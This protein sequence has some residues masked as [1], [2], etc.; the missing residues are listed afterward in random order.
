MHQMF[1]NMLNSFYVED[2]HVNLLK[3]MLEEQT[4]NFFDQKLD[5]KKYLKIN[6]EEIKKKI[7]KVEERFAVGEIEKTF[8]EK[9]TKKFRKEQAQ[10]RKELSQITLES[11][12][13]KKVIEYKL[14]ISRK[15]GTLLNEYCKKWYILRR[16]LMIEEQTKFEPLE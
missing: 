3:D 5:Q 11:S 12:N 6:L 16:F 1:L 8:Y 15:T 13:L 2:K 14:E 7:E 10:I 9:F 4:Q